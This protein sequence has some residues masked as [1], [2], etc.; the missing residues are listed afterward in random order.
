M[1][2]ESAERLALGQRG[3]WCQWWRGSGAL[4]MTREIMLV[5]FPRAASR[6]LTSF[7]T[8]Q[9]SIYN[10]KHVVSSAYEIV[11]YVAVSYCEC[12]VGAVAHDTAT[13]SPSL[14]CIFFW[15]FLGGVAGGV[16]SDIRS[17]RPRL[18]DLCRP[19]WR[20]ARG[21]IENVYDGERGSLPANLERDVVDWQQVLCQS[22]GWRWRCKWEK[23][24]E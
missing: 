11:V 16:G 9:I 17:S 1:S 18:S 10:I 15:Y 24:S 2:V 23:R 5:P 8:F 4:R 3:W 21:R 22:S 14:V 19:C 13:L 7:L 12:Q 6:R 20:L